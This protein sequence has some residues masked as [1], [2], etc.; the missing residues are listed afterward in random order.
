MTKLALIRSEPAMTEIEEARE[1]LSDHVE[2]LLDEA[3]TKRVDALLA[4]SAELRAERA[5]IAKTMSALRALPRV[6]EPVD[7]VAKV[8]ARLAAEKAASLAPPPPARRRFPFL[9]AGL[10]L[11]LAAAVVVVVGTTQRDAGPHATHAA[12]VAGEAAASQTTIH[13]PAVPPD[14]VG[15]LAIAAGMEPVPGRASAFAGDREA[16]ARF[17][18]ELRVEAARR[19]GDVSGFLPEADRVVVDVRR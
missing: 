3:T 7:M 1:L 17:V 19:G 8:R 2:G 12:G 18:V 13:A 6:D 15:R 16:A 10:G 14:V 5:R 11:A 4:S 9:E